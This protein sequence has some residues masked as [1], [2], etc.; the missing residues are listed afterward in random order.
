MNVLSRKI[1]FPKLVVA[2]D[3]YTDRSLE[4]VTNIEVVDLHLKMPIK[5]TP[6]L[7]SPG[8]SV[9]GGVKQTRIVSDLSSHSRVEAP[10]KMIGDGIGYH[11]LESYGGVLLSELLKK[12]EVTPDLNQVIIISAPDGYR[13]LLSFGEVFLSS[14]GKSIMI[15]DQVANQPVKKGGNFKLILPDDLSADRSVKAV[16]K[17]EVMNLKPKSSFYIIGVGCADTNLITLEAIS[18]MG[19]ADVFVCVEDLQKRFAKYMGNKPV[20]FDPF[21]SK[22]HQAKKSAS[23]VDRGRKTRNR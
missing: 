13:T 12:A 14:R 15:A 22:R 20:L 23:H 7:F 18:A 11:G 19:K 9:T 3:F 10:A 21:K 6:D 17:I 1:G 8:F 16:N 2:N 4:D 5:K